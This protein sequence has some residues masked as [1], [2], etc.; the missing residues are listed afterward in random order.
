MT[1]FSRNNGSKS[2][3]LLSSQTRAIGSINGTREPRG[4][5]AKK[6]KEQY[7]DKLT[8]LICNK[9]LM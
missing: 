7:V 9:A 6:S 5:R 8:V 2:L 1:D 4:E 3:K